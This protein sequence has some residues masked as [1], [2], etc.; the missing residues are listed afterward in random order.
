MIESMKG[1]LAARC[2]AFGL[3]A[4][5]LFQLS[6]AAGAP[7]GGIAWGGGERVLP[8]ALREASAAATLYLLLAAAALL[9]LSGDWGRRLPQAP[10]KWFAWILTVQMAL[11]TAANLASH[12]PAERVVMGSA[13]A[14]LC[15]L[16]LGAAT[17]RTRVV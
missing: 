16:C 4:F 1:R 3:T 10:S 9:V 5:A 17:A 11:N 8:A 14:V 7:L 2:A 13:T 15:L 12:S 6:L